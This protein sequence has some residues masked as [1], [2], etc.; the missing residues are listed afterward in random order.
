[1]SMGDV[2]RKFPS[3]VNQ[4]TTVEKIVMQIADEQKQR[5]GRNSPYISSAPV[6]IETRELTL[7]ARF[8]VGD[9]KVNDGQG[10]TSCNTIYFVRF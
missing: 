6:T 3:H 2:P 7:N 1:M 4:V 10:A 8:P 5:G 9:C